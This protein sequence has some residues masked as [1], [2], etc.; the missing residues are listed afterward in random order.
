MI[1]SRTPQEIIGS[2]QGIITCSYKVE[3]GD[4]AQYEDV[5]YNISK[6]IDMLDGFVI[7]PEYS[8]S[9]FENESTE[10]NGWKDEDSKNWEVGSLAESVEIYEGSHLINPETLDKKTVTNGR[11]LVEYI[12]KIGAAKAGLSVRS[13]YP[14]GRIRSEMTSDVEVRLMLRLEEGEIIAEIYR[15]DS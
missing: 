11:D 6:A 7:K 13:F 3:L 9:L 4:I 10:E 14:G 1:E 15:T 8:T 2:D 12:V 5:M